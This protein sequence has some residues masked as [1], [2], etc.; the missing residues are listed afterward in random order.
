MVKDI[1]I[2]KKRVKHLELLAIEGEGNEYK[3]NVLV[4]GNAYGIMPYQE[5]LA[6]EIEKA[7][8]RPYW[9][10]FRG[11]EGVPG[12][13]SFAT[14]VE[15]IKAVVD[16]LEGNGNLPLHVLAH[17]SGSLLTLE[18]LVKNPGNPIKSLIIYGLLYK[19]SRRRKIA[20]RKFELSE[21]NYKL[22]EEDWSYEPL[23]ALS[24]VKIPIFFCHAND[25]AN[26]G[27]GTEEEMEKA[28]SATKKEK[29]QWFDEGY[30]DNFDMIPL[31]MK[32][33]RE[34]LDSV[35]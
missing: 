5:P 26:I 16:Y 20:E 12:Y 11:Q 3:G 27:R 9:F 10:A 21:V 19:M 30:D 33:Y 29:I 1:E 17:C 25:A 2:I 4:I 15:D 13:Y 23:D 24:K 6:E 22:S 34:F 31:Y 18:Y 32:Y 8:Y 28:L 14:G 7:G 35:R